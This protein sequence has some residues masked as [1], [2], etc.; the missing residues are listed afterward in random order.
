M[1]GSTWNSLFVTA[2]MAV[3]MFAQQAAHRFSAASEDNQVGSLSGLALFCSAENYYLA[4]HFQPPAEE[5]STPDVPSPSAEPND[6]VA[7]AETPAVAEAPSQDANEPTAEPADPTPELPPADSAPPAAPQLVSDEPPATP[8]ATA[9]AEETPPLIPIAEA[10]PAEPAADAVA[11]GA[12][13]MP[14]IAAAESPKD[15]PAGA[16]STEILPL[17]APEQAPRPAANTFGAFDENAPHAAPPRTPS[18]APLPTTIALPADHPYPHITPADAGRY[19]SPAELVR[20]RAVER[21]E[22]RR[23]RIETRKWLGI[24]PLRPSV[25]AVPYTTVEEPQQLI[26][27]A[28]HVSARVQP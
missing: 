7:V 3:G 10:S 11:D 8:P 12:A 6:A 2:A 24:I 23:Q 5:S 28:P 1:I 19:V 17:P 13:E 15:A 27:V 4:G 16:D 25:T 21:G 18:R 22:Q 26:L 20:E 14:E 9:A